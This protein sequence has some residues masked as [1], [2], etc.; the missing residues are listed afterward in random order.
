MRSPEPH[1]GTAEI[2]RPAYWRLLVDVAIARGWR[3]RLEQRTATHR[4]LT[5]VVEP[6]AVAD[7]PGGQ[8]GPLLTA[9]VHALR[10]ATFDLAT[11]DELSLA[12]LHVSADEVQQGEWMV[13]DAVA[14]PDLGYGVVQAF[15]EN[16][17][18]SRVVVRF[19]GLDEGRKVDGAELR[20]LAIR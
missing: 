6:L 10:D 7:V 14:H 9:R 2:S 13:G 17:S 5:R 19:D 1:A 20:A 15:A 4:T 11:V 12:D 16:G 3:V 8:T 18:P